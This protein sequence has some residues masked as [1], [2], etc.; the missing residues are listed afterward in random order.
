MCPSFSPVGEAGGSLSGGM[1]FD[2]ENQFSP[3]IHETRASDQLKSLTGNSALTSAREPK[4]LNRGAQVPQPT[5]TMDVLESGT[6]D[7]VAGAVAQLQPLTVE[8]ERHHVEKVHGEQ[9]SV[10]GRTNRHQNDKK[11]LSAIN[12]RLKP[13]KGVTRWV[14]R[15]S[16]T[17]AWTTEVVGSNK[18]KYRGMA[19]RT[20]S[21]NRQS[22]SCESPSFSAS[23]SFPILVKRVCVAGARPVVRPRV[24]SLP[25]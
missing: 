13:S 21:S 24:P 4:E 15:R 9:A 2:P 12:A 1:S 20:G 18:K 14:C 17:L 23:G 7:G 8:Q 5:R 6:V 10:S 25:R 22:F 16:T 19:M 3:E 11:N